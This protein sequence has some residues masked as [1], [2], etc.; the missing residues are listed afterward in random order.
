MYL[1]LVPS[2]LELESLESATET[3]GYDPHVVLLRQRALNSYPQEPGSQI[4]FLLAKV[5]LVMKTQHAL[6]H[7]GFEEGAEPSESSQT[8]KFYISQRYQ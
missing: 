1:G 4:T 3:A 6:P 2:V 8:V 7:E 5:R